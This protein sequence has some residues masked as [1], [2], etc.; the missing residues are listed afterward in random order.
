MHLKSV[1]AGELMTGEILSVPLDMSLSELANFLLDY[2]ITGALVL[3]EGGEPVGVIS[4]A[5]LAAV[6]SL[7]GD[8]PQR[9]PYTGFYLQGWED[10]FDEF[11][12][13]TIRIQDSPL[14]V[15]D[16]MTPEVIT[17]P[18]GASVMEIASTM[19]D[20]Q[21][22]RVFVRDGDDIVGLVST[23]D[24]LTLLASDD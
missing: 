6:Q 2:D 1:T 4:A 17:V 3:G 21:I 13:Q 9:S 15:E 7:S 19:L 16:V 20:Q 18:K 11:D 12:L 10:Q 22:H 14:V 24:L 23:T 8:T 5:D